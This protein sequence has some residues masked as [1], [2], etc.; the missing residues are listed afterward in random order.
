MRR[1]SLKRIIAAFLV[2]VL[3]TNITGCGSDKMYDS[4]K[5]GFTKITSID[6]V[7]FELVSSVARNATAITNVSEDMS[8]EPT[9]TYFYKNG[10]TEYFLFNISSIV[11]V[12]QKNTSF[13]ILDAQDKK[14]AVMAGNICNIWFES[15]KKKLSYEED[16]KDGVYKF[17]ATVTAG[18]TLTSDLYNDFA[19]K[20]AII[21]DGTTEWALFI[22][23]I[24][25]DYNK[26]EKNTQEIIQYMVSTLTFYNKPEEPAATEPAVAMGGEYET[27]ESPTPIYVEAPTQKPESSTAPVEEPTEIPVSEASAAPDV[28]N[29]NLEIE[30][31]TATE[32]E[33]AVPTN[34]LGSTDISITVEETTGTPSPL[35]TKS[36]L[37]AKGSPIA[38]SNQKQ[39]LH[40]DETIY[41]VDI[42]E[43]LKPGKKAYADIMNGRN[44]ES[45]VVKLE[46]VYTG[47][48]AVNLIK[49]AYNE[50]IVAGSY[51]DPPDGC[52]FHAAKYVILENINA[53][54]VNVKLRGM[55]GE[56]LKFRGIEYTQ[57][58]YDIKLSESEFIC[59][60][61]VP[62]ACPEY[63]L[64]I[65]DGTVAND[66]RS[67]YYRIGE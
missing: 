18:V 63:A 59:F 28:Q 30:E 27:M 25:D 17:I 14:E 33:T 60:Y 54:Y 58:T 57:R 34:T 44:M 20:L 41:S 65:G 22:G 13:H 67:A 50:G 11:C 4:G 31:I 37:S 2:L 39:V 16:K 61:A 66:I 38:L 64:E 24:G 21:T 8:F 29:D 10:E 35:P 45:V 36:P 32:E 40:D 9:Q 62:N 26:F 42:Y 55:D 46:K 43:M 1:V 53:G 7:S 47:T 6:G 52:T 23:S 12:A 19:G 56:N 5:D 51:F 3:T 48:E 15:P 49:K